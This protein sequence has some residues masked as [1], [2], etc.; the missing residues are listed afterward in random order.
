[1]PIA[2]SNQKLMYIAAR[3]IQIGDQFYVSINNR[4]ET[5]PVVNI[6]NEFK[7]GYFAPLTMTGK[8]ELGSISFV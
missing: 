8:L 6:T 5:S 3:D 1:M 7:Q 4:L 2:S